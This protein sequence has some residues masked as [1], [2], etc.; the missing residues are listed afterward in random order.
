[1]CIFYVNLPLW[2][3]Q[4]LLTNHSDGQQFHQYQQNEPITSTYSLQNE[5]QTGDFY[6]FI[7]FIYS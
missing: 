6:I 2:C 5:L 7:K 4:T 3:L 1:M